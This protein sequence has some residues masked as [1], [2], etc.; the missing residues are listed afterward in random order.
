MNR[1]GLDWLQMSLFFW[2][3]SLWL[4]TVPH[5]R[6]AEEYW[7]LWG[8]RHARSR[9][10]LEWCRPQS[11]STTATTNPRS[12]MTVVH[13]STVALP[14]PLRLTERLKCASQM[15]GAYTSS[16][17]PFDIVCH[18]AAAFCNRRPSVW[19]V[20]VNGEEQV[21]GEAIGE[22]VILPRTLLSES[23]RA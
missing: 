17:I 21:Y 5:E 18:Y 2:P 11:L 22:T 15:F 8:D 3:R 12:L 20:S 14:H 1:R 13:P 9:C 23:I 16:P 4:A 19:L 10:M 6:T 7:L